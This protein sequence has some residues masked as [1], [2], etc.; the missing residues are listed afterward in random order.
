[1]VSFCV[2]EMS[3][4]VHWDHDGSTLYKYRYGEDGCFD[5]LIVNEPRKPGPNNT[6]AVGS[7]VEPGL[8]NKLLICMQFIPVRGL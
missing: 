6:S 7:E 2:L 3:V 4:W 5:V 8:A 1:M